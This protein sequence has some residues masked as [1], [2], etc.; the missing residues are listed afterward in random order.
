MCVAVDLDT[1]LKKVTE[2]QPHKSGGKCKG[3]Q[4]T[5]VL[6]TSP[7]RMLCVLI[8]AKLPRVIKSYAANELLCVRKIE[9]CRSAK[10]KLSKHN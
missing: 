10:F 3:M 9:I 5:T 8:Y 7:N 1:R 2:G 4:T 6:Q